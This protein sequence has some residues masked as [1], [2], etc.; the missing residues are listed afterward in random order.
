LIYV[1]IWKQHEKLLWYYGVG[2]MLKF[3]GY[4]WFNVLE[5][6]LE[7]LFVSSKFWRILHLV[8]FKYLSAWCWRWYYRMKQGSIQGGVL[9]VKTPTLHG[10]FSQF[11]RAFKK[12]IPNPPNFSLPFKNISNPLPWKISGYAHGVK[13][14][15][16]PFH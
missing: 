12:K 7:E 8:L 5:N 10:K 2:E 15:I 16:Q 14:E 11:A 3:E 9:G 1:L 4:F 13:P 6:C